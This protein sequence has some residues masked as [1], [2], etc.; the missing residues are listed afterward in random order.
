M[1]FLDDWSAP[2]VRTWERCAALRDKSPRRFLEIGVH[3][4][5]S[6]C[7]LME[8]RMRAGAEFVGVDPF[9]SAAIEQRARRNIAEAADAH[10]ITAD[11]YGRKF[12]AELAEHLGQRGAFDGLYV[13]ASKDRDEVAEICRLAFPLVMRGGVLIFDDC[14]WDE[15]RRCIDLDHPAPAGEAIFDALHAIGKT[16]WDFVWHESQ[17]AVFR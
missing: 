12:D 3:E 4:G 16:H 2:Y 10:K 15:S 1:E 13:D 6:A 8:H 11:V 7:W 17:V 5:R 9:L 14:Y